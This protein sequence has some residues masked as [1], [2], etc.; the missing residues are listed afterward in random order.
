[1]SGWQA[2]TYRANLENVPSIVVD[3]PFNPE[4][5]HRIDIQWRGAGAVPEGSQFG[6]SVARIPYGRA[7]VC[8]TADNDFNTFTFIATLQKG[9]NAFVAFTR[10]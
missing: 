3:P 10:R 5:P 2:I 9:E 6:K 4:G 8:P 7:S 1:M